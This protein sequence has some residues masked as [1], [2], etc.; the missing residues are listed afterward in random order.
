V[1]AGR[2]NEA[3]EC[4]VLDAARDLFHRRGVTATGL[5]EVIAASGTG[6]GQIYH[7][8]ADKPDL[9]LAVRCPLGALVV[10][11]TESQPGQRAALRSAFQAWRE[12][13]ATALA[14]LQRD[15]HVSDLRSADEWA[16]VL[17]C[18][19]EGGVVLAQAHSSTR[20]LRLS[21][22]AAVDG[23]LAQRGQAHR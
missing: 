23:M 17:L 11:L 21:L 6:K 1:V 18:A 14:R 9:V 3:P 15:G 22:D 5:G 2:I 4:E 19:Y 10:E 13:L 12:A 8:F 16:E 7:Y 20:S